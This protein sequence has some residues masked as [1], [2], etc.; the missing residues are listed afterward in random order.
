MSLTLHPYYSNGEVKVNFTVKVSSDPAEYSTV[1]NDEYLDKL[2]GDLGR[3]GSLV[4]VNLN[5][6]GRRVIA[7]TSVD[8]L[9]N[10]GETSRP[11]CKTSEDGAEGGGGGCLFV[12]WGSVRQLIIINRCLVCLEQ[13]R[14]VTF[15]YLVSL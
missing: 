7:Q 3:I 2:S 13:L 4:S 1:S 5:V 8:D 14:V 15:V 9:K 6:G 10:Q 12:F 11:N